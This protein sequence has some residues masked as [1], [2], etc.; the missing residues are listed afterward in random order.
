VDDDEKKRQAEARAVRHAAQRPPK[1]QPDRPFYKQTR[2]WYIAKWKEIV[3]FHF[4]F[5]DPIGRNDKRL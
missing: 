5:D 1:F 4:P 3:G 2:A